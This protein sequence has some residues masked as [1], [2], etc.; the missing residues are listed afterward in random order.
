MQRIFGRAM[1]GKPSKPVRCRSDVTPPTPRI[2]QE[3]R[4][5]HLNTKKQP[6]I[7]C[8]FDFLFNFLCL[9]VPET[10]YPRNLLPV[11]NI[12]LNYTQKPINSKIKRMITFVIILFIWAAVD[13]NHRPHPYQGCALTT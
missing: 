2:I 9:N 6:Q 13:S 3:K 1:R 5:A 4:P 7:G 11:P 8:L 12:L 10:Y